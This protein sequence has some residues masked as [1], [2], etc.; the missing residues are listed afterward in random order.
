MGKTAAD[1]SAQAQLAAR[2]QIIV[3]TRL[4]ALQAALEIMQHQHYSGEHTAEARVEM[5]KQVEAYIS[6]DLESFKKPSAIVV[7]A[8]M[9]PPGMF[10]PGR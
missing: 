2:E 6:A 7:Q 4:T 10:K 5:A 1:F 3:N 9:P 8:N